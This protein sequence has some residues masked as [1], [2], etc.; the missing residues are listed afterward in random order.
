MMSDKR[1]WSSELAEIEDIVDT[2]YTA[3]FLTNFLKSSFHLESLK[4]CSLLDKKVTRKVDIA[5]DY[6][7]FDIDDKFVVGYGLDYDG[8][9]RNLKYIGELTLA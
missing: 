8:L 9:Y 1:S 3:K 7:G 2:G 4:L 5:P 6:Y